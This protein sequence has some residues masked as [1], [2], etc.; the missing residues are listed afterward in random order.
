MRILNLLIPKDKAQT[1]REV[2]TF[3]VRWTVM[4]GTYIHMKK[5][6]VKVFLTKEEAEIRK[7]SQMTKSQI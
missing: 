2:Q 4:T 7:Y 6:F 5:E 1:I 3:E